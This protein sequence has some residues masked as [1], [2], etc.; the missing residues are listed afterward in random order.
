MTKR[1]KQIFNVF[2]GFI[3]S[4]SVTL[5]MSK[6]DEGVLIAFEGIDAA[7]K[8]TQSR[9]LYEYFKRS[10]TPCE[11]IGFPDYSTPIGQEIRSFLEHRRD[12]N[13]ESRHILYAGNRYEH[14]EQIEKWISE[15]KIIVINRYCESNFAYGGASGLP[16]NWLAQIESRMPR[17][18]YI[19]YLKLSPEI[20]ASRKKN[21]D[22]Y[23]AD[24]AFL[25]RVASVYEALIE[26]GRWFTISADQPKDIIHY[27]VA[28]T[29]SSLEVSN[30]N[31]AKASSLGSG[32]RD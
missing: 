27:E 28:K 32:N 5:A 3:P 14:K 30:F 23:E 9:M 10:G 24:L 11:Y 15:G 21:R 12:Y 17:A 4:F 18:D 6:N 8:N 29:I 22:R 1:V 26:R 31:Q 7:G 25:K 2:I 16:L 20:S 19:F 13:L